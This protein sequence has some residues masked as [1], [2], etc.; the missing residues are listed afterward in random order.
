ML[1]LFK[2]TLFI[3]MFV[4]CNKI[5][6]AA[7]GTGNTDV[8]KVTMRK[9]ELCTG[10][11][12]VDFDDVNTAAACHNAVV[13]GSGDVEVDIASVGAGSAAATYGNPALLPLGETYTHMRVTIDRKFKIKSESALDT[14]GSDNTDN[15]VTIATADS[16]Y[17]NDEATDKY[18]HKVAVAEGGTNAEMT[19]YLTNGIQSDESTA[20]YTQCFNAN[21][22]QKNTSWSWSYAKDAS[23]LTSAIAMRTM[24]SSL[25]TDDVQFI[26]KLASPYTVSLI[27]PTIDISFGTRNALGVQE[28][29]NSQGSGTPSANDGMC[30]FYPE[31]P[32]VTIT[33]K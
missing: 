29:S 12:V 31:E 23:E 4:L 32:I 26:Y 1:K 14:G 24:R 20:S 33:I 18:T 9:V 19:L 27:A 13:I 25:S 16:Q 30:S 3:F 10:Y 11:T 22:S 28:V 21:C 6:I 15:C 17:Q 5:A 7:T 2:S 8:Y